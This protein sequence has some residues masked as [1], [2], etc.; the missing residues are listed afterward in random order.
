MTRRRKD[1]LRVLSKEERDVLEQIARAR[2]EPASH[3][4]RAKSL[5]ANGRFAVTVPASGAKT[6]LARVHTFVVYGHAPL[7]PKD[8]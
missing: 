5:V 6:W 7:L 3:V 1:P 2:S 8:C 4:A